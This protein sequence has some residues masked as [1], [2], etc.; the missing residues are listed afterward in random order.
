MKI[1]K[2]IRIDLTRPYLI[3]TLHVKQGDSAR[4]IEVSLF[5]EIEEIIPTTEEINVYIKK[6]DGMKVR[7]ECTVSDGKIVIPIRQQ[8][9]VVPG[10]AEAEL[11]I[12]SGSDVLSTPIFKLDI[13]PTNIDDSEVE[14]QNDFSL[15]QEALMEVADLKANGLKGDK[16]PAATV[17]V[18]TVTTGAAG[19]LASVTNSGTENAAIF[20]FVIPRGNTG[21]SEFSMDST[22]AYSTPEDDADP[23]S[24]N[25]FAVWAGRVAKKIIGFAESIITKSIIVER[26]TEDETYVE[27][28]N[29][30]HRLRLNVSATGNAGVYDRTFQKW[31]IRSDASGNRIIGEGW[32]EGTVTLSSGWAKN[33]T[34][35]LA[36]NEALGIA[37][38]SLGLKGTLSENTHT[39]V[40]TIP[41]GFRAGH[42]VSL[43]GTGGATGPVQIQIN[44]SGEVDVWGAS[45]GTDARF[46][47]M[48]PLAKE[49]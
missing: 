16:G 30:L 45:A 19:S 34:N 21:T 35:Y 11:Q 36:K 22:L 24:G 49:V 8:S 46:T 47:V 44:T 26:A 18:G 40:A 38:L 13:M 10:S 48:Y 41:P 25:T 28:K 12:I 29:P 32:V 9:V 14:S 33:Q 42:V 4:E 37:Y 31:L 15:L 2:K 39:V 17:K 23:E 7:N 27:I 1:R 43:E 3:P 5:A 6:P 20:D